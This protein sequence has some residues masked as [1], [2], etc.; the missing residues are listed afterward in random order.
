M[1][2]T[3]RVTG[4]YVKGETDDVDL[5]VFAQLIYASLDAIRYTNRSGMSSQG[6]WDQ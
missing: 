2:D 4:L 3:H 5:V 1:F 6:S